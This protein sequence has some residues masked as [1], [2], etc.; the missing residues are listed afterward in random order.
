MGDVC[1]RNLF[2]DYEIIQQWRGIKGRSV[3]ATVTRKLHALTAR[4]HLENE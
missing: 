2:V 3:D 4:V 1:P